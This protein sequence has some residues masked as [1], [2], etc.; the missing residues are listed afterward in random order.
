MLRIYNLSR[1]IIILATIV[2]QYNFFTNPFINLNVFNKISESKYLSFIPYVIFLL[3]IVFVFIGGINN[4]DEVSK[5][6]VTT[7][8]TTTTIPLFLETTDDNCFK[9]KGSSNFVSC[10]GGSL[11]TNKEKYSESINN[12]VEFG[13]DIFILDVFGKIFK[14]KPDNLYLDI[15]QDVM[16]RLEMGRGESGL[17]GLAFHPSEIIS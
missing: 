7:T 9:W 5:L 17:F 3:L 12:I 10:S 16:N 2:F 11:I 4:D 13:G 14:N 8:T 1:G 6:S 15:S